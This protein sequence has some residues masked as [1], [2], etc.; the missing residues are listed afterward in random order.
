MACESERSDDL[1]LRHVLG[2]LNG[3]ESTA[4]RRHLV[5]CHDC[6]GRVAELRGIDE[7]LTAAEQD[8]RASM[9]V[10]KTRPAPVEISVVEHAD[11]PSRSER[12]LG[13][14]IVVGA[15]LLASFAFW[16]FHLRDR[17]AVYAAT[18]A[19]QQQ[20]LALVASGDLRPTTT[21]IGVDA[22]VAVD[23]DR[24][25]VT[26]TGLELEDGQLLAIWT[27]DATDD[28]WDFRGAVRAGVLG[29]LG[30]FST[31]GERRGADALRLTSQAGPF[32]PLAGPAGTTVVDAAFQDDDEG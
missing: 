17:E 16:N 7:H 21:L 10:L 5:G 18:V 19:G 1:A 6:R 23:G 2:A 11:P 12:V 20:A 15:I 26:L 31:S 32:D 8:E 28:T 13:V 9:A 14:I 30:S 27:H 29:P 24:F 22:R 4:F 3:A 25:A